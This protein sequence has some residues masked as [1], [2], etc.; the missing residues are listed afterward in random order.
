VSPR[1]LV[2]EDNRHDRS[3]V[4]F[5]LDAFGYEPTVVGDGTAAIELVRSERFD[6]VLLDLLMPAM[7]GF[8][9]LRELR[10]SGALGDTPVVALTVL[11]GDDNRRR[12][13]AAGFDGHIAKP[14][15]PEGFAGE[16]DAFL[17]GG[18]EPA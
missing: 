9:T 3:L 12:A 6:L 1:I 15:M 16:I 8:E 11:A 7:D 17:P 14:I 18:G 13:I 5:L 10:A 4:G 2:V